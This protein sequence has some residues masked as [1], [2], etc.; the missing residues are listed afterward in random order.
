MSKIIYHV[1]THNNDEY[2]SNYDEAIILFNDFINDYGCARIYKL[3]HDEND[4]LISQ[5]CVDSFGVY[6]Q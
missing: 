6:P 2:V 1:F 4:D 3:E 5:D